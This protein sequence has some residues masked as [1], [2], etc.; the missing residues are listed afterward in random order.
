MQ[1]NKSC[2]KSGIKTAQHGNGWEKSQKIGTKAPVKTFA[3]KKNADQ[4]YPNKSI[5]PAKPNEPEYIFR[6]A[7]I[8]HV[9][10]GNSGQRLDNFLF[11]LL[12]DIPKSHIY[13]IIRSGEVRI[14]G[15]RAKAETKIE[16][17]DKIRIPPIKVRLKPEKPAPRPLSKTELPPT[18]FEDKDLLVVNKPA[19]L[20]C[21]GGSGIAFGLIE[22]LR[23]TYPD[24]QFLELVH[25]LDRD[26]SGVLIVAKSRRAL[27]RL[28]EMIREGQV[29]K[30]YIVLV[31]GDWVNDRQ[32]VKA[33]LHKYVTASG[34][35]RVR[36]DEEIGLPSHTVFTLLKRLK[37]ASL[38][39]ADL[40]TGRTHQIRVHAKFAG[41][42]VAGDEK[43]GNEEFNK[44]LA[45]GDFG[46]K[47]KRMFLHSKLISFKHPI[48][49]IDLAIEAPLP[50]ECKK[51]VEVLE[52]G[53]G[54]GNGKAKEK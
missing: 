12:K 50:D 38:L 15:G 42:P 46:Y 5:S 28:H 26:T 4:K 27:V 49:G 51:L 29:E 37:V 20:A 47:F 2:R 10:A 41:H 53:N 25:R 39:E 33:P 48:S 16:T 9:T 52:Y 1:T 32:H 44:K 23:A 13:R 22:R 36:P 54:N 3:N 34:E 7:S 30:S 31:E 14:S 43:Y 6:D 18:L 45:N 35:R 21:H 24:T 11:T 19:G 40:K 17:G 8:H